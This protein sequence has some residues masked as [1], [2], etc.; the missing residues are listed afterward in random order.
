MPLVVGQ[1]TYSFV[2]QVRRSARP[3]A[4]EPARRHA[5]PMA[6]QQRAALSLPWRDETH[7]LIVIAW[8]NRRRVAAKSKASAIIQRS[9]FFCEH[10]SP[11]FAVQP[12][13][14]GSGRLDPAPHRLAVN[15]AAT[16]QV[17]APPPCAYAECRLSWH[18]PSSFCCGAGGVVRASSTLDADA[19][20]IPPIPR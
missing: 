13:A 6:Q 15:C 16:D 17:A 14:S 7:R 8:P 12:E 9:R 10:R 19:Y 20:T 5:L 2:A 3:M 18:C 11:L 1:A 4:L